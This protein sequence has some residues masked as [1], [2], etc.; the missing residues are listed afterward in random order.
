MMLSPEG[1][2][3]AYSNYAFE[4]KRGG[5]PV[6]KGELRVVS[7]DIETE[8]DVDLGGFLMDNSGTN[9]I[10]P[11]GTLEENF[12]VVISTPFTIGEE[13][14]FTE[15]DDTFF[16]MRLLDAKGLDNPQFLEPMTLTI[17]YTDDE[18]AGLDEGV[19][20]VYYYDESD[21]ENPVWVALG[22]TVDP[23]YNEITVEIRHF[24]KFAVGG[25]KPE[26]ADAN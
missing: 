23:E 19:I 24:S 14:E 8:V 12:G 17:R 3:L 13:A 25:K 20:E 18:V 22:G 26:G 10:V 6:G 5:R 9:L 1:N 7:F 16:A 15:G 4:N 2:R 21:P 11:P